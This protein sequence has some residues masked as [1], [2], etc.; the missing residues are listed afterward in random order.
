MRRHQPVVFRQLPLWG[1]KLVT[2]V[3]VWRV[4][5]GRDLL[6]EGVL[7]I[8]SLG[9]TCYSYTTQTPNAHQH[10]VL[11]QENASAQK[12]EFPCICDQSCIHFIIPLFPKLYW[13]SPNESENA[14]K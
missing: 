1:I 7:V 5:S 14:V 3:K 8:H 6:A 10:T 11:V 4:N 13:N 9:K 12:E 2:T